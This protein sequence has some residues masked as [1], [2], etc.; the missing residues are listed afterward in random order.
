M[1]RICL[2]LFHESGLT[3]LSLRELLQY[4]SCAVAAALAAAQYI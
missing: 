2:H 1:N 3:T 4:S